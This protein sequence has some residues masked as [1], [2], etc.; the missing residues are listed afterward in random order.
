ML[1]NGIRQLKR[2]LLCSI[3][4]L[5]HRPYKIHRIVMLASSSN[6]TGM[7]SNLYVDDMLVLCPS[8]ILGLQAAGYAGFVCRFRCGAM[9]LSLTKFSI[10]LS[11]SV[12]M[13]ADSMLI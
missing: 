5:L 7:Y 11:K 4:L 1:N 8:M 6:L 12:C 3:C 2:R 13:T 9:M 10:L